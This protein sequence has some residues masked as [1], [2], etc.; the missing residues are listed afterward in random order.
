MIFTIGTSNRSLPEFLC[1]LR[2]RRITQ[3]VDV[4]SSPYSRLAHFNAGQ[5]ARW[6]EAAGIHYRQEGVM[7]GGRSEIAHDD[8]DYLAALDRLIS[9]ARREPLAIFCAEGDPAA[10]HRSYAVGASLL[11]HRGVAVTNISRDGSTETI[12]ATLKRTPVGRLPL[13]ARA[14]LQDLSDNDA[15]APRLF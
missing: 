4:R 9:A 11:A 3:I 2:K 10:C 8:T 7:L 15:D 6:S 12:L 5:I 1:E 14:L 13:S